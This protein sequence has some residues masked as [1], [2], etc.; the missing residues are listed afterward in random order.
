MFMNLDEFRGGEKSCES[1]DVL[2]GRIKRTSSRRGGGLTKS[3]EKERDCLKFCDYTMSTYKI[4]RK[5]LF[6]FY[7][8]KLLKIS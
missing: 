6:N 1:T 5:S 4:L 8:E 3:D 7:L 2:R